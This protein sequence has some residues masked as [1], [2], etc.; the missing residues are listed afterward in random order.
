MAIYSYKIAVS[1][2]QPVGSLVNV[3]DLVGLGETAKM[4]PPSAYSAYDPGTPRNRL[5]SLTYNTGYP[6][7]IWNF[8]IMTRGQYQLL[9]QNYCIGGGYSGTVTIMA[10]DQNGTLTRYNAIMNI[11]RP[12]ELT[13]N[14]TRYTD[15]PITFI[16]LSTPT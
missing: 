12:H 15:V 10:H 6:S 2:N 8:R 11:P 9:K 16:R 3:E 5:D 13:R 1:Y 14:F 4:Y 7:M